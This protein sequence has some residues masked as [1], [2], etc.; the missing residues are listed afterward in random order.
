[1]CV[2]VCVLSAPHIAR[3]SRYGCV[4]I[5]SLFAPVLSSRYAYVSLRANVRAL[6]MMKHAAPCATLHSSCSQH[7]TKIV[8]LYKQDE[9]VLML[10]LFRSRRAQRRNI[11]LC[12]Q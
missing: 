8:A 7:H 9:A 1:M 4:E 12:T 10:V 3:V 5:V 6:N 2:C 11:T